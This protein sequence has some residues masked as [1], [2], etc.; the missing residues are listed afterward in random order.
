MDINLDPIAG[1]VESLMKDECIIR[2]YGRL[3]QTDKSTWNETT[4][5][6]DSPRVP[7]SILYEGKCMVYTRGV[8]A[9][10][11]EEGGNRVVVQQKFISIPRDVDWELL[12]EDEVEITDVDVT[13][14]QSM[15]GLVFLL[16]AVDQGTY[17][18]SRD[19]VLKDK[20]K[21]ERT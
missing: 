12:P 13:S 7:H 11:T 17:I 18:A 8:A 15:I 2:R 14:D 10:T 9:S 19:M 5:K 21:R 16:E 3:E 1:V 20:T 4:G 6:Y